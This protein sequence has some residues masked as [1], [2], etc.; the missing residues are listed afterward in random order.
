M[1][2]E[3]V[4]GE[5]PYLNETPLKA[6]YLIAQKGKPEIDRKKLS[7]ELVDFLDRSLEVQ[8]ENRASVKELL[9]LPLM[10]KCKDLK[11]LSKNIET[12]KQ[13]LK[14]KTG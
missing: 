10:D 6:L 11:T 5:P 12:A 2:I 14:Q 9:A 4:D 3:M 7:P 1:V 13:T 8:A